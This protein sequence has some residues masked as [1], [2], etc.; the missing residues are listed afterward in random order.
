[1]SEAG[2]DTDS[3]ASVELEEVSEI[4][5][6]AEEGMSFS[7]AF[8]IVGC[9]VAVASYAVEIFMAV[10]TYKFKMY[11]EVINKSSKDLMV[12]QRYAYNSLTTYKEVGLNKPSTDAITNIP[13]VSAVAVSLYTVDETIGLGTLLT[14]RNKDVEVS[15]SVIGTLMIPRLGYNSAKYFNLDSG[16]LGISNFDPSHF[17]DEFWKGQFSANEGDPIFKKSFVQYYDKQNDIRISSKWSFMKEKRPEYRLL[18]T[19]TD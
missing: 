3:E 14:F 1:V 10:I 5:E 16:L 11:V 18:I 2:Y 6:V 15:K 13:K 17:D 8:G 7:E 12:G 19:I 4:V 9:A